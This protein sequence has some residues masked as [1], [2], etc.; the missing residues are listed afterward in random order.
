M[1]YQYTYD[2]YSLGYVVE[3]RLNQRELVFEIY[4][5]IQ[6]SEVDSNYIERQ[7]T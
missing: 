4:K 2:P 6:S 1:S 7:L 5:I 3:D